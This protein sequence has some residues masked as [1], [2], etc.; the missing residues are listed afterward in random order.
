MANYSS[1]HAWRV[2]W[3]EE[4][5]GLQSMGSQDLVTTTTT[6]SQNKIKSS[7]FCLNKKKKKTLG[8]IVIVLIRCMRNNGNFGIEVNA[9]DLSDKW[10][11]FQIDK[12]L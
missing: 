9:K 12:I 11:L 2:T 3:T 5:G 6:T 10:T 8:F 1:I 7:G 4:P